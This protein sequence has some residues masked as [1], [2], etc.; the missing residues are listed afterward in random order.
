MQGR[1]HQWQGTGDLMRCNAEGYY[2]YQGRADQMIVSGGEN[3]YPEVVERTIVAHPEGFTARVFPIPH[4]S[5]GQVLAAHVEC[6]DKENPLSEETLRS[7]LRPRLS[8]A[9]M[10]HCITFG[11]IQLLETGKRKA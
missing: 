9:E 11:S 8:R 7:W 10:P 1:D 5:F 3:I 2:F 6:K 4:A